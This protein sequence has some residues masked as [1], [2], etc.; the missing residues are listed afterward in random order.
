MKQSTIDLTEIKLCSL[1]EREYL[2]PFPEFITE[3]RKVLGRTR[4]VVAYDLDLEYDALL[5]ME[6]GRSK[7]YNADKVR[8]LAEY[9][10]VSE[11]TL[12]QKCRLWSKENKKKYTLAKDKASDEIHTF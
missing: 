10:G 3:L 8:A 1:I 5:R 12:E 4:Q 7:V 9:Y 6:T 2:Y 11:S